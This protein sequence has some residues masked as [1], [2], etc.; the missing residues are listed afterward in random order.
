MWTPAAETVRGSH[1]ENLHFSFISRVF[2][3]SAAAR[4]AD[5]SLSGQLGVPPREQLTP[6]NRRR[7]RAAG[8]PVYR[9]TAGGERDRLL[10]GTCD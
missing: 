9:S 6:I 3:A 8:P 7:L 1:L 10:N 2:G 5:G 4:D